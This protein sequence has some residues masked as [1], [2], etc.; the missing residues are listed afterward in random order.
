[1][2]VTVI[3]SAVGGITESDVNLA[4]ASEAIVVGFNVRPESKAQEE[5][6]QHG[7][8]IRTYQIIYEMIDDVKKAMEGLLTPQRVEKV[9]GRA[10]VLNTFN[11]PKVGTVAGVKVVDGKI[12][13]S[14]MARIIRDS[15][16]VYAS[17]VGSLRRF[18][19][20]VREVASGFECGIGIENYQDIK[21]GDVIEAYEI[22]E[23]RP[24]LN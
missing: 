4:A 23:I 19:D 11:V 17:K 12:S 18:K 20:D 9:L 14:A 24:S 13:R 3:H 15:V 21:V 22:E 8:E 10:E 6:S 2:K 7:I 5:A 1:V 16:M